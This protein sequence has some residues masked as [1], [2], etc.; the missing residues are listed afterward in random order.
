M[1]LSNALCGF[2]FVIIFLF[3][4]GNVDGIHINRELQNLSIE[5]EG[6]IKGDG[7]IEGS[8]D[9]VND[10]SNSTIKVEEEDEN[11]GQGSTINNMDSDNNTTTEVN[12]KNETMVQNKTEVDN[13]N[14]DSQKYHV[15]NGT[16]DITKT[17]FK[18]G[19]AYDGKF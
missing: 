17:F 18:D 8:G 7:S 4:L 15:Y 11:S 13:V 2:S 12:D 1:K 3:F 9:D 6:S 19:V 10:N 14:E 5:S 16:F